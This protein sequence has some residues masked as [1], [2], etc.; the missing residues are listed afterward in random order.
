MVMLLRRARAL[1]GEVSLFATDCERASCAVI[2]AATSHAGAIG[3]AVSAGTRAR[4]V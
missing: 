2:A 1:K 4:A 3:T